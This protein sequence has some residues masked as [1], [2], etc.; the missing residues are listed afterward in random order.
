MAENKAEDIRHGAQFRAICQQIVRPRELTVSVIGLM[1]HASWRNPR[2]LGV[3]QLCVHRSIPK[4]KVKGETWGAQGREGLRQERRR[5]MNPTIK[6]EETDGI[7]TSARR[8]T[9][10]ASRQRQQ[11]EQLLENLAKVPIIHSAC[12]RVGIA[13]ASFYRW[14]ADDEGF[15]RKVEEAL[16]E[17]TFA[18]FSSNCSFCCRCRAAT[19]VTR[20]ADV[21]IPSVS[22]FFM[23]GFIQRLLS[24][25]RPSRPCAPQVSPFTFPFGM[26]R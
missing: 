10:V 2:G 24:C 8:V 19:A 23:V 13:R 22:S 20:R 15:A 26:L 11:K 6:K 5:C 18:K 16:A 12:D 17:G 9:A 25:R 14:R 4:G 7:T 3:S 21:V 1:R